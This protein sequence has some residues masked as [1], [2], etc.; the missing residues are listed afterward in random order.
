MSKK[1]ENLMFECDTFRNFMN[2]FPTDQQ[3]NKHLQVAFDRLL[4][5]SLGDIKFITHKEDPQPVFHDNRTGNIKIVRTVRWKGHD[6]QIT[7]RRVDD[8]KLVQIEDLSKY[9]VDG[10]PT[11]TFDYKK[12]Q[13][14]YDVLIANKFYKT[15]EETKLVDRTKIPLNLYQVNLENVGFGFNSAVI[16][17]ESIDKLKGLIASNVFKAE[18]TDR[19]E[20]LQDFYTTE[21]RGDSGSEEDRIRVQ[22]MTDVKFICECS[23]RT[24]KEAIVVHADGYRE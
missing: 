3:V 23:L 17:C 6:L 8:S 16:A 14:L 4:K 12:N 7:A 24:D 15:E 20:Y 18:H 1:I 21:Y 22:C 2:G 10:H 11:I 13:S 19:I 9:T 5:A